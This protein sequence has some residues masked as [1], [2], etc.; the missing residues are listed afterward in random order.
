MYEYEVLTTLCRL[1]LEMCRV[2][3]L[4]ESAH[5]SKSECLRCFRKSLNTTPYKYLTEYRLSK[6]AALLRETDKPIS[7][8]AVNVGFGQPSHFGKCFREKT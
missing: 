7:D 3:E 8:I 2:V 4:A 6:A 1:W 5:V